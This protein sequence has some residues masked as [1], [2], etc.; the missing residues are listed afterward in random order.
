MSYLVFIDTNILLDFYRITGGDSDLSILKKIDANHKK[1]IT[2]YQ[3][4][5][6]YKKNRQRVILDMLKGIKNNDQTQVPAYLKDSKPHKALANAQKQ[7][8]KQTNKIC[9]RVQKTLEYPERNDPVYQ[10]AQRLFKAKES[11]HLQRSTDVK[12]DIKSRAEKRHLYGFPPRKIKDTSI[13]D[14]FNWEWILH[15]A[16]SCTDNIVIVTRDSDYGQSYNS[17]TF[18]ND[19]LKQEFKERVGHRQILSISTKLTSAFKQAG[20]RVT[21]K[22]VSKEEELIDNIRHSNS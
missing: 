3:V 19:F 14:A 10:T 11:C 17:K 12:N 13:G 8:K 9:E 5:M 6:E 20:I 2:S 16:E 1:L 18:V 7:V 21:S 15:C 22:E 4:E